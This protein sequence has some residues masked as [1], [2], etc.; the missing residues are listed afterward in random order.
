M[1][2]I[3]TALAPKEDRIRA[4]ATIA[5]VAAAIGGCGGGG[6]DGQAEKATRF[7]IGDTAFAVPPAYV[8]SIKREP[9][10]FVR[11]K[12]SDSPIELVFDA[13]LQRRADR[14][15]VPLLFS[16]NDGYAHVAYR[17]TP[18]GAVVVCRTGAVAPH[19]G[20]ATPLPFDG[21]IWTLLVPEP[22]LG[23]ADALRARAEALLSAY[24]A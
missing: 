7:R 20:C 23:E 9:P 16:I 3:E 2:L 19:G 6:R 18:A 8:Q 24:R 14:R 21:A 22:R 11:I 17:G 5:L 1:A 4:L 10:G 13:R 15:G 12:D